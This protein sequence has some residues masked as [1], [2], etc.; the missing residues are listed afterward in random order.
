MAPSTSSRTPPWAWQGVWGTSDRA[1]GDFLS[2]LDMYSLLRCH[3]VSRGRR[4]RTREITLELPEE[5]VGKIREAILVHF[6]L[7]S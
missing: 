2:E 1:F 5:L 3:I 4:G 7:R 6:N